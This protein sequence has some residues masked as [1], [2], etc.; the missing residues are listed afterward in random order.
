MRVLITGAQ[1]QVGQA[2]KACAEPDIELV[3]YSHGELDIADAGMTERA[4]RRC[5]P[6]LVINAAAYTAVDRAEAQSEQARLVNTAGPHYLALAARASGA[7][8][9]HISTDFVFNGQSATAYRPDSL[10]DPQSVYGLTKRDGE[11][12]VLQVLYDRAVVLRTAWVYAAVGSNFVKTMLRAMRVNGNVKVVT[13]QIG[14]PTSAGS[15]AATLWRIARE[16]TISGIHH[17]TDAGVASWYDFAVA[18]AEE[19]AEVGLVSP[20]VSVVP[21]PTRDY[22]TAARR[23]AFSVLDS[24]SLSSLNLGRVHWR[25]RLREVLRE[26]TGE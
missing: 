16:P 10:T 26:V 18:I 24:S 11:N 23:P 2:L 17:W 7:R 21:I 19:G 3:A 22:P 6:D 14:T 9:V 8:L 20:D 15:V 1:G 12:A 5:K 25:K 4:L 13:D